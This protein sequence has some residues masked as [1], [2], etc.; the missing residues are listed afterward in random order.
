MLFDCFFLS[1]VSICWSFLR[2]KA[3]LSSWESLYLIGLNPSRSKVWILTSHFYLVSLIPD[4]VL[5][6][7]ILHLTNIKVYICILKKKVEKDFWHVGQ[8]LKDNH[9]LVTISIFGFLNMKKMQFLFFFY[10]KYAWNNFRIWPYAT[11]Y[12]FLFENALNFFKKNI[13]KKTG[14]F[15]TGFIFYSVNIQPDIMQNW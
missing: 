7:V 12:F 11:K 2:L 9:K 10:E 8:I 1:R 5:Y 14:Y 4:G 13:L 15:N 3:D 6:R